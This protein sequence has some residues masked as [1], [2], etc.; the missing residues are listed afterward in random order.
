MFLAH[1]SKRWP[2]RHCTRRRPPLRALP[3]HVASPL[4]QCSSDAP[5]EVPL[6]QPPSPA[7]PLKSAD[8]QHR[9][10]V[11]ATIDFNSTVKGVP[12]TMS[13]GRDIWRPPAEASPATLRVTTSKQCGRPDV[14]SCTAIR[15]DSNGRIMAARPSRVTAANCSPLG[16][17]TSHSISPT[18]RTTNRVDASRSPVDPSKTTVSA[19]RTPAECGSSGGAGRGGCGQHA[20]GDLN[21]IQRNCEHGLEGLCPGGLIST[22]G[23][24]VPRRRRRLDRQSLGRR[25]LLNSA[26]LDLPIF[27]AVQPEARRRHMAPAMATMGN[28]I[29]PDASA[30]ILPV[31]TTRYGSVTFSQRIPELPDPFVAPNGS[32]VIARPASNPTDRWSSWPAPP[33]KIETDANRRA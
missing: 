4:R 31:S 1:P 23:P 10:A 24:H 27:L 6:A 19:S 33:A 5:D 32:V 29:V 20:A 21:W 9:A 30:G 28:G 7:M 14:P 16:N 2:P 15:R 22:R 26:E 25:P 12:P 13:V 17:C 18:G 3:E 11:R 8:V